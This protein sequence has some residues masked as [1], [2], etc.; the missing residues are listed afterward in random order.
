[1]SYDLMVFAPKVPP[2][3][4]KGFINW[5][6]QQAEWKE[7]HSYD[8]PEISTPE[9]RAWFLEMI[10]LYPAMNGPFRSDDVDNP[11]V[12]DYSVGKSVIYSAFAWSEA[13]TAFNTMFRLAEKHKV[14][15]F[16][17]S[18]NDG[19]VWLPDSSGKYVCIHGNGAGKP[20]GSQVQ[21]RKWWKFWKKK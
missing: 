9:L 16:D 10:T 20:S 1:M 12:T 3:D 2:P 19:A 5:Y 18:A 17:V 6:R 13:E 7:G 8:N 14:G 21:A 15:F 4:R 11:K